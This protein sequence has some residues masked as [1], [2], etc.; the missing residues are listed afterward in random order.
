MGTN[1]PFEFDAG[2][3]LA[4]KLL[5]DAFPLADGSHRDV[6]DYVVQHGHLLAI[7]ARGACTGLAR[8]AQLV[9][10]DGDCHQAPCAIVLEHEGMQVEIEPARCRPAGADGR[11]EH[12]AQQIGRASCRER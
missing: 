7:D 1:Q 3:E 5:D 2:W 6:A 4:A 10:V 8:P 9:E 11:R 12:R